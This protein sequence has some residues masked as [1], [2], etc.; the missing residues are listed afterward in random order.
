MGDRFYDISR[1]IPERKISEVEGFEREKNDENPGD[2]PER[3]KIGI[4]EMQD[5]QFGDELGH[6]V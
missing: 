3:N 6:E 2:P 4:G 1:F 5:R